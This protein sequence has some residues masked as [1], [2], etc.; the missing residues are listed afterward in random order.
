[1]IKK[2]LIL[3]CFCFCLIS[4]ICYGDIEI[5]TVMPK[6]GDYQTWGNELTEG[7][8]IAVD[9]LNKKGGLNGQKLNL[10]S[11]DDACSE[12][13]ALSTA[14]MLALKSENKPTLVIGP[15]CSDGLE[16]IAKTYKSAKIFQ[17]VPAMLSASQSNK[18]HSGLIKLFGNK[19]QAATD[20][21]SFYN[22]HFAGDNVA[23]ISSTENQTLD[24]SIL[25]TFK[26]HGK[27]SLIHQ[28]NIQS[29]E[30]L[31]Q[32]VARLNE[33]NE[34]IVLVFDRPKH[35]AKI[36][37]KLK[38]LN[39]NVV[40]I[41]SRYIAT[42]DFFKNAADYLDTTHFMALSELEDKPQMAKEF[43]NLR[44]K[45][46]EFK[47]LNIYGYTAVKMW[48][49]LVKS[50]KTTNYDK[51]AQYIK[52]RGFKTSWGESFFNNGNIKK[53]LKYSFYKFQGQEYVLE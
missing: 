21:F 41:T 3:L 16:N 48:A 1:M 40:F 7:A 26:N 14:Q 38:Q 34:K 15:Y 44:L 51:L 10:T 50:A 4:P 37:K 27:S 39:K 9:E 42:P 6:S 35:T 32:L 25:K 11:I 2:R 17:I 36:I 52:K 18:T 22:E 8:R 43:A 5:V 29:F 30:D 45:G 49:E 20:L 12:T 53:P 31:D 28:Y 23:L 33:Q 46:I 47:G 19:E 24:A 13:L